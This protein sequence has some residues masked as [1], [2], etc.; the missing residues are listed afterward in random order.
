MQADDFDERVVEML[1]SL[2]GEHGRHICEQIRDG[3]LIG[4][5]NRASFIMAVIRMFRDRLKLL[6]PQAAIS[7]PL[8]AGPSRDSL[9]V[10]FFFKKK[11]IV[12]IFDYLLIFVC[13]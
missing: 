2:N 11:Y 12:V 8:I 10:G 13:R 3:N 9:Q 5:Q 7:Q 1:R 6:G 4:V